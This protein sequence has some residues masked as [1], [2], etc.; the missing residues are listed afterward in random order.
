M[1]SP[2]WLFPFTH[3]VDM[4]AIDTVV[5]LAEERGA[6]LVTVS[7]IPVPPEQ[8][9]QGARLEHIQQSKDFL[10]AVKFKAERH[11]VPIERYEVFSSNVLGSITLLTYDQRCDSIVLV[12]NGDKDILLHVQEKKCL[13]EDPPATLVLFRLPT[14]AERAGHIR[15]RFLSWLQRYWERQD[16]TG[17]EQVTAGVDEPCWIRTEEHSRG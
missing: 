17:K 4:Q 10:E 1:G 13:L 16:D 11:Q 12:S 15:T 6:T 14:Q 8:R 5:R 9:S 2:R 7:L 3:G